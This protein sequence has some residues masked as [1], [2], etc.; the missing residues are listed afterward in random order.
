M[1]LIRVNLRLANPIDSS[2]EAPLEALVDTGAVFSFIPADFLDRL[3]IAPIERATFQLGDGRRIERPVGE[4]RFL[5]DGK[6]GVTKVV[7][8]EP[9]DAT[10]MGVLALETLGLEVDPLRRELRPTTLLFYSFLP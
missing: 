1:G 4:A 6:Q 2:R 5:Y 3:G 8:A 7:F 9:S 10:V